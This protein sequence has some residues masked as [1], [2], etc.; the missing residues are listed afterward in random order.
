MDA[1][2]QKSTVE[3]AGKATAS[4]IED[5]TCGL[6]GPRQGWGFKE[7]ESLGQKSVEERRRGGHIAVWH[8]CELWACGGVVVGVCMWA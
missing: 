3:I 6:H 1:V 7:M 2:S 5:K 4:D 8:A